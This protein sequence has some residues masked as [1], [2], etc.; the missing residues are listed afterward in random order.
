MKPNLLVVLQTH[1]LGDSQRPDG[2]RYCNA[3]KNEVMRRCTMSLI[4]SINHAVEYLEYF[5]FELVV[6]DD[7]SDEVSLS[8]LR[9]NLDK[10]KF[11]TQLYHL[12]TRGIMPSILA[13]YEYGNKNGT[14]WVY[15]AQDDYLYETTAIYDMLQTAIF[16][17]HALGNFACIYP[18]DDPYRYIPENTAIKSHVIRHQNRHWRTYTMT[19]SCFLV[20]HD[21][22]TKNWDLFYKMGTHPVTTD[23]EKNTINKLFYERNYY[24]FIPIPSLAL[25]VQY[26]SEYDPFIDYTKLWDKYKE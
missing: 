6:L 25:H 17:T 9:N 23:M 21:V 19:S 15:F 20:H 24:L 2:Q 8:K 3:K 1:S 4:E 7:H 14:D 22:L 11:K 13:C 5:D 12:D 10:A 18:Y 26:E 16:T